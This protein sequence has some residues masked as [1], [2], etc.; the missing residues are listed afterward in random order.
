MNANFSAFITSLETALKQPLPG[1]EAQYKMAPYDRVLKLIAQAFTTK[2]MKE[3]AV[4]CL[5]YPKNGEPHFT[6]ILRNTYK[7]IHSAQVSFPGGKVEEGDASLEKTALRE[8][9]EEIGVQRDQVK[10][11][12]AL[13][14]LYIPPSGFHVHPFIGYLEATPAFS[15]DTNEVSKIIETPLSMLM[16]EAIVG[17]KKIMVSTN[18]LKVNYPYFDILG[19]TV[20]GATAMML[21]ELKE[22]IGRKK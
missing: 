17:R 6:L 4:L 16:D 18:K 2:P 15:P 19:E 9:E 12:G 11:I 21:S 3:S 8:T 22:L 14:D 10:I 5:F 20:W 1:K 13:T 7:G